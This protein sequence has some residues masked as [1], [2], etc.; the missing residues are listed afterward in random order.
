MEKTEALFS[1]VA[2]LVNHRPKAILATMVLLAIAALFCATMIPSQES[3]DQYLDKNSPAGIIYDLYNNRYGQDTY[4]LVIQGSDLSDPDLLNDL[5]VLEKQIRRIDHVGSAVSIADIVAQ[6]HGGTI[7]GTS[8][9]VTAITNALPADTRS[10]Y[11]PDK[12]MSLAYVVIDQ[13]VS[14]DTSSM[15]EPYVVTAI[16]EATLPPGVSIELTGNT[17]YN[18]QLADAMKTAFLTVIIACIMLMLLVLALLFSNMRYW[19]LPVILL[20]FGLFF[21]F[22]IMGILQIPANDG[23]LAAFPILL[24]LG[25]D[26]AVQFHSRFDEERRKS[27]ADEAMYTTITS[28]GP[29]VL[30]ALAATALGFAAMYITPIPMIHTFATV[31]IL[32]ITCS[33]VTTLVGFG[34]LAHLLN[35]TPKPL[36]AGISGRLMPA[37]GKNLSVLA[38][39]I[40]HHAIPVLIIAVVIAGIGI[41]MDKD[42]LI[43]MSQQSMVPSDLPAQLVSDKV[44]SVAGSFTP[45]PL[46]IRG[47]DTTTVNGITWIDRMCTYIQEKNDEIA[48]IDSLPAL[49][50]SKNN[51][52]LPTN[53]ADLNRVLAT[54]PP[55]QL[56]SYRIDTTTSIVTISTKSMTV[57][58]QCAFVDNVQNDIAWLEPP[59]G[60]E[61]TPTGDF[62]LYTSLTEQVKISKDQMTMLGFILILIFLL[63]VYRTWV[64][65]TP[66]IPLICVVGWN[67]LAMIALGQNYNLLTAVLGSMTIGV[68]SEYTVLVM[69]RYIEEVKATGDPFK[70]RKEAVRKIGAAVTVSGLVTA[71][72]FSALLFAPFPILSSFGLATVFAVIFSLL[73]SIL[74]MPAALA[75]VAGVAPEENR[76][77]ES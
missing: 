57:N 41:S 52:V 35:Y 44:T 30:I 2:H 15:V 67:S 7:P 74:I 40:A 11:L 37:Y 9:E 71:S 23:A 39:K 43:D 36:H 75:L 65:A 20:V 72:G 73:G 53:Q 32:G 45:L 27:S 17:P 19:F 8:A 47:I 33:Y 42:I 50:R 3:S 31:S 68:G 49:I 29:S 26:Y 28:T 51:G 46:Y 62:T 69:E 77:P 14:S 70:S 61:V 18:I 16:D 24:G 21:M 34:A 64:A 48:S 4:I 22:G 13:G 55:E 10:T 76:T 5:L 59:A 63:L 1:P 25:I 6:N 12:Q 38:G 56:A 66:L 58:Q 60:S 54:I